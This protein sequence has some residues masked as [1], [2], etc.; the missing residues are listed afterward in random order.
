[1]IATGHKRPGAMLARR[2]SSATQEQV[3]VHDLRPDI[4]GPSPKKA[5]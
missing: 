1:M 4:F 2:I 3:T 5:A